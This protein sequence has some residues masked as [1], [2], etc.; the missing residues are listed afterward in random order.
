MKFFH[1]YNDWAIEGLEKNG[2]INSETGFKMQHVF[3]V[4][5]DM[6][7]NNYAKKDGKLYNF[8][9]NGNFPFYVDRIAGGITYYKYDYSRENIDALRDLLGDWFLGFQ[10]HES[11]SNFAGNWTR[12]IGKMGGR[13]PP[14]DY[15]EFISKNMS[16]SAVTPDGVYLP[17]LSQETPEYFCTHEYKDKYED[18]ITE[19]T[20]LF[21]RRMAQVDGLILPCDSGH[22]AT[23]IF[24]KLG[25]KCFMPEVGCQIPLMR[26]EVALAR[27]MAKAYGKIWGA[28]YECWRS[29]TDENGKQFYS[30]PCFNDD[31][32]NEWYLTQETHR[33]D[34]TTF[35]ENGGSSRLLQN[36]IYYYALMAGAD[37]FSEEWGLNCSYSDMKK[38]TLS[39][40]GQVKKDFI[41][42]SLGMKGMKATVPFAVVMPTKYS[43]MLPSGGGKLGNKATSYL[44]RMLDAADIPWFGHVTD[45]ISLIFC[46]HGEVIGNEGHTITNSRFGDVFDIVYADAPD[47]AFERYEYLIDATPDSAFARAKADKCWKILESSDIERLESD[48]GR[49][50]PEVMP[51]YA[52]DLCWLVSK[53][54]NGVRYFTILNN[55]GNERSLSEGNILHREA[56]RTVR[57]TF[58]EDVPRL[59]IHRTSVLAAA[60]EK[61]DDRNYNVTVPAAGFAVLRY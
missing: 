7:F 12:V 23:W 36:R 42:T 38:F 58:K 24:N 50:I 20:E 30:M 34:F 15:D 13:L 26:M 56:D 39:E 22:Q 31:M 29:C 19:V 44:G 3:S 47:E 51:A 25:L 53:D 54:E 57:V 4:P 41:N 21:Q 18:F 8:M 45:V 14:Y 28:Y 61:I 59:D 11:S 55:E 16:T 10:L 37:L 52:D 40:Y 1:V 17:A 60:V 6:Q 27:G 35:G 9:K 33:D 43:I 2:L 5:H 49:L 32:S 46:R 48:L